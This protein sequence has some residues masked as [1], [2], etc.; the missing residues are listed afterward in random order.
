VSELH[1]HTSLPVWKRL[2]KRAALQPADHPGSKDIVETSEEI[3]KQLLELVVTSI[4]VCP[5]VRLSV[6]V[7]S[8]LSRCRNLA[9]ASHDRDGYELFF[10]TRSYE[11]QFITNVLPDIN[12][13]TISE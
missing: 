8:S 13:A 12:L 7:P 4:R 9:V 10:L 2:P 5:A 3:R 1:H 6:A 11:Y